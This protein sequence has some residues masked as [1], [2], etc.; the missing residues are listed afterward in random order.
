[1]IRLALAVAMLVVTGCAA[2]ST[3]P[4]A[5]PDASAALPPA[6]CEGLSLRDPAGDPVFLTGRWIGSG[7][8]NALPDPSIYLVRQTNS[9]VVWVGLSAEDG[10]AVGDSWVETFTG[11]LAS[12]GTITGAWQRVPDGGRGTLTAEIRFVPDGSR[13][14]TELVLT[15]GTG[16]THIT[17]RWVREG[18]F[19]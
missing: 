12:D 6:V 8:P 16:D 10:E 4:S 1:V 17:K 3:A 19:E 15:D 14:E 2:A 7:D 18:A 9:C 5:S 13:F 11:E